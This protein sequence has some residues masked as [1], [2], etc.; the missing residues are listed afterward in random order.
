M[1]IAVIADTHLGYKY[2]TER[3]EDAFRNASY[4]FA[5]AESYNPDVILLLGDIFD[6][7]VAKPEV[8]SRAM[9]LFKS[10]RT[11]VISIYGTHETRHK[12]AVNP[13]QLLEQAGLLKLLH[14]ESIS[15]ENVNIFGMS[16]VHDTFAKEE[17]RAWNPTPVPNMFNILLLHQTFKEDVP[18]LKNILSYSDLP[19]FNLYLFGHI[20]DAKEKSIS[21]A[22]ILYPGS[23]VRTQLA[24]QIL[25]LGFYM[26]EISNN[27]LKKEFVT[28]PTREYFHMSIPIDNYSPAEVIGILVTKIESV[29][30]NKPLV[31]V[32]LT[33]KLK[34]GFTPSDLQLSPVFKRFKDSCFLKIDKDVESEQTEK[35]LSFLA[36]LGREQ[37]SIETYGM[38]LLCSRLGG[39]KAKIVKIFECL[40][41]GRLEDAEEL[42]K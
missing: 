4:A 20:H 41:E 19:K 16:G 5:K 11:D 8:L 31:K 2:G 42:L 26:L 39:D 10:L 35:R 23:T 38:D 14:K 34:E 1:R 24:K 21:G 13:V 18:M 22:P 3:G 7:R 17:L 15:V 27:Q 40:S 25:P 37:K 36:N 30:G 29:L 28:I 33:G 32:K 12:D 6:H 9:A